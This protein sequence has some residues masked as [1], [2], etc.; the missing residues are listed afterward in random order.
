MTEAL[1]T[2][3]SITALVMITTLGLIVGVSRRWVSAAPRF[4]SIGIAAAA[5]IWVD[6]SYGEDLPLGMDLTPWQVG[7]ALIGVLLAWRTRRPGP[8]VAIQADGM[9]LYRYTPQD[10]ENLNA[11]RS[12]Q[13]RLPLII[14]AASIG[15]L[16]LVFGD[17]G[18][19]DYVSGALV[20]LVAVTSLGALVLEGWRH[21]ERMLVER[22][23][24]EVKANMIRER[25]T[26]GRYE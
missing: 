19:M 6:S 18:Y 25:E 13:L 16:P 15:G 14:A 21:V 11:A 17:L 3:Q 2:P 22:R 9:G 7:V 1:T 8:I 12:S 26:V 10:R 24:H 23:I 4:I 20:V 5:V